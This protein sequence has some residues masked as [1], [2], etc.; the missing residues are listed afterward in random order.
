M[1]SSSAE[2][3]WVA[4]GRQ[5]RHVPGVRTLGVRD[6]FD[7]YPEAERRLLLSGRKIYYP[8]LRYAG[9][10]QAL[11]IPTYPGWVD[12]LCLGDKVCQTRLFQARG[13][14]HPR[15]GIYTG[16]RAHRRIL[17]DFAFPFVAK[18]A[19]RSAEGRG[20]VLVRDEA[21]LAGYLEEN[22][23]AYIQEY[24]P[25]DRDLR[26]VVMAGRL[27]TAYWRVK[28][29]GAFH[30]NLARGARP[31][32]SGIPEAAL[33]TALD[34]VRRC[35]FDETGLDLIEH[36]GRFFVVEANFR[37]GTK[38]LERAGLRLDALRAEFL[39]QGLI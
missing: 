39:R 14:P 32:F 21:G 9:L 26:V 19:V 5:L 36:G 20:V 4:I 35:G 6:S 28:A 30:A 15:T 1:S 3:R 7:A 22:R 23:T 18:R 2:P 13:V 25:S 37:F 33:E 16:P 31:D 12:H 11:G 10:F 17:E 27:V 29:P 8:T 34:A 38:G 24:L